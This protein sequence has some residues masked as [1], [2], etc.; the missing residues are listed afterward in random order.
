MKRVCIVR[1]NYYPQEAHVRRNAE[2]LLSHGYEV[3]IICLKQKNQLCRE[4][5]H[6]INVYRLPV[7]HLRRGISRYLF[8][9][10]VFFLFAS[11]KLFRLHLIRR[12]K[13]IE[14]DNLP[15]FLVFTSLIPKLLGAKV[16]LYFFE[17]MPEVFADQFNISSDHVMVRLL[18]W[19]EKLSANW[20]DHILAANG[21][22]QREILESRGISAMKMSVVLNVPYD[23]IILQQFSPSNDNGDFRL[24]THTS[25]LKRYGVQTLIKAVP[26]L[27][28]EI[29]QLEVKVLG[30]GEYRPQLEE[31]SQSLGVTDCVHFTGFV[32][33]EEMISCIA[34]AHVGIVSL[35]PQRQP[36]M[37]NKLFEYLAMGKPVVT[38]SLPAIK[39]Y[40]DENS[41]MYYQP[42]DEHDLARCILELYRNPE[43]RAALAAAGSAVYQKYRWSVMK[44][45]Y[46]KIFQQLTR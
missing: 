16:V 35:F 22:C 12:Y 6:G 26:L 44:N 30:E 41:V 25:L 14:V 43:K 10:S 21:I 20:A 33:V 38:T 5:V 39:P 18:R 24:I 8:E 2:A 9:Y 27:K 31:L 3:D 15:D 7:E 42:D 17:L 29:P 32:S 13:V 11:W 19:L 28:K 37:P 40:F 36:Q 1:H 23:R 45:E 4:I 46:L 34:N